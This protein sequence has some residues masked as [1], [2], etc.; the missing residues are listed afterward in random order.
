[1]FNEISAKRYCKDNPELI[2][3][4]TM[5]KYDIWN[6]Y[7]IH[8]R[9]ELTLD[10]NFAHSVEELKQMGMYYDR[11]YYELIFMKNSDHLKLHNNK[12]IMDQEKRCIKRKKR[13]C[14]KKSE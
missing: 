7:V 3:N 2:E 5:A 8:H 13:S 1:M 6:T 14:W 12:K 10:G 4:Y 9:L 11:P